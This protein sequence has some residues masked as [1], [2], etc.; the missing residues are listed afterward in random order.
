MPQGSILSPLLFVIAFN[1]TTNVIREPSVIMYAD[2]V[3]LYVAA[4]GIRTI[5]LKL[6]KDTESIADW[7][8]GMNLLSILK[9]VK[10]KRDRLERRNV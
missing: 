6:S 9:K 2:D 7:M 1:D 8:D 3:V 5:N 4:D 10:L